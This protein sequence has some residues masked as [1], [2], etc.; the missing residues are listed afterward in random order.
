MK[1]F[2]DLTYYTNVHDINANPNIYFFLNIFVR[3]ELA[4]LYKNMRSI[5]IYA[6]LAV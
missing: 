1:I 4:S 2:L 5:T 3:I 6:K